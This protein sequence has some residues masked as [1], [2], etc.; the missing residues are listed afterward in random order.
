MKEFLVCEWV[1]ISCKNNIYSLQV[2]FTWNA[3][4][5]FV[6]TRLL[7]YTMSNRYLAQDAVYYLD[8]GCLSGG[9]QMWTLDESSQMCVK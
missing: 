5:K 4:Y 6:E 8:R 2:L 7:L 3:I 9:K 1:C